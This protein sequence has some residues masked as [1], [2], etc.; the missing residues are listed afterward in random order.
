MLAPDCFNSSWG[1]VLLRLFQT[2]VH[3]GIGKA[4]I[5]ENGGSSRLVAHLVRLIRQ[6][7]QRDSE[8]S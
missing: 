5:Q 6:F 2:V 7:S 8:Q 4:N 3:T 1:A